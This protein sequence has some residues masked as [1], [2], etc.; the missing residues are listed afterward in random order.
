ESID[1]AGIISEQLQALLNAP[2]AILGFQRALPMA[3]GTGSIGIPIAFFQEPQGE[4][5]FQEL[6]YRLGIRLHIEMICPHI[7]FDRAHG[8]GPEIKGEI[9]GIPDD[10]FIADSGS[11]LK[12]DLNR[13]DAEFRRG[14]GFGL[15]ANQGLVHQFAL[16]GIILTC[17]SERTAENAHRLRLAPRPLPSPCR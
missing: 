16:D 2:E 11:G 17:L 3:D 15:S 4:L 12:N 7:A 1:A 8:A 6:Q 5:R 9:T 10:F 14:S 13:S